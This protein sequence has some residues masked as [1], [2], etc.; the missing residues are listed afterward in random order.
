MVNKSVIL[1][2]FKINRY[3]DTVNLC[4]TFKSEIAIH[5]FFA[6]YEDVWKP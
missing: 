3:K 1:K 5:D 6:A 2:H 4:A